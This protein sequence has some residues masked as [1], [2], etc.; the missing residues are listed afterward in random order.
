[1]FPSVGGIN[2]I[3][4]IERHGAQPQYEKFLGIPDAQGR[5]VPIGFEEFPLR[6]IR[7]AEIG[8]V[9]GKD[10][11]DKPEFVSFVCGIGSHDHLVALMNQNDTAAT[12]QSVE[13]KN[14][15]ARCEQAGNYQNQKNGTHGIGTLRVVQKCGDQHGNRQDNSQ[16]I[17]QSIAPNIGSCLYN[18][19]TSNRNIIGAVAADYDILRP[20]VDN[21]V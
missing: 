13:L 8:H 5:E 12:G 7:V 2:E 16:N 11:P 1:M 9:F 3:D 21:H 6:P 19:E 18:H 4:V 14:G 15:K 20:E 10:V 17:K